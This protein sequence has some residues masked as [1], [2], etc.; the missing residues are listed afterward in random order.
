[1]GVLLQGPRAEIL[2]AN[3]AAI[4]ILGIPE[5]Q[6]LGR[7]S[8]DSG[9]R[10][11]HEDGSPFP[12]S[13]HPGPQALATG[14]P[15]HDVV[16][17]WARPDRKDRV[18]LLLNAD[19]LLDKDGHVVQVI[20]TFSDITASRRAD[21]RLRESETRYRLLVENAQDIIYRTDLNGFFTYVNPVA[22][23]I[24]GYSAEELQGKHFLELIREDHRT[25]V[26]AA[27]RRQFRGRVPAT[28]DE[29]VAL[30]RDGREIWIGQ[31]VQLM[32]E[33]NR[34]VGFQAVAR[35][36]TDRKRAEAA[37]SEASLLKSQFLANV[38]HELRTPLNGVI[39]MARLLLSTNLDHTQRDYARIIEE[40]GRDLLAMVSDI[41]DFSR[42]EAGRLELQN[43]EFDLREVLQQAADGVSAA[44]TAK[45]LRMACL[46]DDA[47]PER[48]KGDP[49]RLRQITA[50]LLGNA[51]KFTE[52]G[53]IVLRAKQVQAAPEG[54]LLRVEVTDTGIGIPVEA[55]G[56]LFQ[57]FSQVDGTT[58]RR[59][60]GAGLGLVLS[61]RLLEA[62]RGNIGVKSEPG[63]GSTFWYT[64]RLAPAAPVAVDAPA[65][66]TPRRGR[67]LVVEDN[68][69]NLRVAAALLEN[70]GYHVDTATNGVEAV[71]ACAGTAYD[72]V[73]MDCQ[74]PEMDG[75]RATA[76]I[77]E[78]EK[79]RRRTPIIALTASV[80]PG[81]KE[82]CLAA[83]MDDYLGKPIQLEALDTVLRK[84]IPLSERRAAREEP[85]PGESPLPPGHPLRLLEM[86]AGARVVAEV[87]DIFL[88][89]TPRRLEELR[90]ARRRGDS[91]SVRAIAHN[92]K[93]A[94][95]QIGA[96]EMADLCVQL[97]NALRGHD[98]SGTDGLLDA[99]QLDFEA[100]SMTL[101]TEKKRLVAETV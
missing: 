47:L 82:R 76:F 77:R 70:L 95:A 24:T 56:R 19:P 40:S 97:Q 80:L 1:V 66:P 25:R 100:V 29:F 17:G 39:G 101:V 34:V 33:G 85:P 36:I 5:D 37:L 20:T 59:F 61:K 67:V 87:I 6:I 48:V 69:V 60:G 93:G 78:R 27:L 86:Q 8:L 38:S 43:I 72:A 73:L 79:E 88:Q 9:N 21:E 42:V 28:Y 7:S 41:L 23:R 11:I 84:W 68:R 63:R 90:Q 53:A 10:A 18:W 4:E 46:V 45:R 83:G 81:D 26:E 22:P 2:F 71:E 65:R 75:F 52:E 99:L 49:S 89:T 57:P 30:G 74:M 12:G 54:T 44:A 51:V 55:Q 58:S 98:L 50:H 3:R 16:A 96:R 13:D 62:M 15:V 94:A 32:I 64:V 92:L 35:D 31:N 91:G 14:K